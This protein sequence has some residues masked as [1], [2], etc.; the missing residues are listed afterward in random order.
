MNKSH[1]L[2]NTAAQNEGRAPMKYNYGFGNRDDEN[3]A[4][5]QTRP[6]NLVAIAGNLMENVV[7]FRS[8]RETRRKKRREELAVPEHIEFV[9]IDFVGQFAVH[10]YF[11]AWYQRFGLEIVEVSNF[12]STILFA[13]VSDLEHQFQHFL[14]AI[15]NLIANA[16]GGESKDY[17]RLIHYIESFNLLT[18]AD[19]I[20]TELPRDGI[21]ILKIADLTVNNAPVELILQHLL[22]YLKEKQIEYLYQREMGILEIFSSQVLDLQDIIDNYD[23]FLQVTSGRTTIIRPSVF[24]VA[25]REYGFQLEEV[26][27][28]PIVG[29][30]DSGISSNTPLDPI[31]IRDEELKL[32]V[33]SVVEDNVDQGRGHG[34]AVGA[35][36]AL[37][38]EAVASEY[39]GYLKPTCKLLPIK[40]TDEFSSYIPITEIV[41]LLQKAI[42]KYPQIRIFTLT[43]NFVQHKKFNENYSNYAYLLD[44]FAYENNCLFFIS[45]GNNFEAA[46]KNNGY[47]LAYFNEEPTN[48]CVPAESL[49]NVTI[50]ACAESLKTDEFQGISN[51]REYPTMYSRKGHYN[52]ELLIKK[53]KINKFLFKPDMVMAGGDYCLDSHNWLT[54]EGDASMLLL[55]A[56]PTESFYRC[57][58]TSFA[59]PLAANLAVRLQKLYPSI[60]ATSIK[61]LMINHCTDKFVDSPDWSKAFLIGHGNMTKDEV[62]F[63]NENKVSLVVEESINSG[64]LMV[65]PLRFP[66]Y[67]VNQNLKKKNGVLQVTATLCFQFLPVKDNQ[68]GYCPVHIAFGFFRNQQHTDILKTEEKIKSRLKSSL[69][70]WSQNAR[71]KK[72]PIPFSNVQKL[73]FP[74]NVKELVNEEGVFKL[75][76]H[77][78]VHPQLRPGEDTPYLNSNRFS[79]AITV[80]ETLKKENLTGKLYDEII[81]INELEAIGYLDQDLEAEA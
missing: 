67:L 32:T 3:E 45:T 23:I 70:L 58:G 50:G 13:V 1:V 51:G 49:N 53:E 56:D 34:T 26:Q 71:F 57:V 42:E 62:L 80:E 30:I 7:R 60:T 29:I 2:L 15:D 68:L 61:A 18:T 33:S 66:G 25:K 21:L 73:T 36:V 44:K 19:I 65:I 69:P 75:G 12:G 54:V 79:V 17:P 76:V 59:T 38:A 48:L 28:L 22:N 37:G 20:A 64:E 11:N 31:V 27:D 47:N 41:A 78:F 4:E 52:H 74:V 40:V 55:S 6:V 46:E 77:C 43:V 10:D 81:A 5:E 72:K 9:K 24:N 39:M 14:K 16:L 8:S 63:S 35:L